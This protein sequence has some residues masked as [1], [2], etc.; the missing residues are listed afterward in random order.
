MFDC[1]EFGI[2]AHWNVRESWNAEMGSWNFSEVG[3]RID[4]LFKQLARTKRD[5]SPWSNRNFF[6]RTRISPFSFSLAPHNE[7]AKPSDFD[8][9]TL[10]K[11]T[12]QNI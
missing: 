9:L 5:H 8:G 6:S 7:V 2:M 3:L 4:I 10:L 11:S 1:V 12:F